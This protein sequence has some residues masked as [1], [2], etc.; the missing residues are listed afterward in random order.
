MLAKKWGRAGASKQ[1]RMRKDEKGFPLDLCCHIR[2]G[3]RKRSDS[4]ILVVLFLWWTFGCVTFLTVVRHMYR[5]GGALSLMLARFKFKFTPVQS[6]RVH[7]VFLCFLEQNGEDLRN[8]ICRTPW[9]RELIK[10]KLTQW[11][12]IYDK[13]WNSLRLSRKISFWHLCCAFQPCDKFL[14]YTVSV[15]YTVMTNALNLVLNP[16]P[17][18][19]G[20][21]SALESHSWW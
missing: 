17:G 3:R 1:Q 13:T 21:N 8:A 10:T 11:S 7:Q 20:L 2:S 19:P 12:G 9:T 14:L 4:I 16:Y 5:D 18:N 6:I 15:L